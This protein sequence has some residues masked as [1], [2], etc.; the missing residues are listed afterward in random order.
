MVPVF[1]FDRNILDKLESEDDARVT[2]L[3]NRMCTLNEDASNRN[4]DILVVHGDPIEVLTALAKD[5]NVLALYTNKYDPTSNDNKEGWAKG[6]TASPTT[7]KPQVRKP[8]G[9]R[10]LCALQQAVA[11]QPH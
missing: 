9:H 3:H 4:S 8:D 10:T 6:S 5:P 1:V 7:S 11:C 2:F